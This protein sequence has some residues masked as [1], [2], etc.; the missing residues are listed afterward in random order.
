ME[1]LGQQAT[2]PDARPHQQ[3]VGREHRA[4]RKQGQP[5]TYR[6]EPDARVV[7]RHRDKYHRKNQQQQQARG[8][9]QPLPAAGKGQMKVRRRQGPLAEKEHGRA[10]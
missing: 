1:V 3:P 4:G 6:P 10:V 8:P 5:H 9:Q 7:A 2:G